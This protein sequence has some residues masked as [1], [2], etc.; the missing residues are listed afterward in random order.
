MQYIPNK[1]DV[2]FSSRGIYKPKPKYS[3]GFVEHMQN[4]FK[5]HHL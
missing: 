4:K 5:P 1:I 2:K 3:A